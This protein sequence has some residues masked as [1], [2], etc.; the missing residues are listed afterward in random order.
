MP[1]TLDIEPLDASFGAV[2][3]GFRIAELDDASWRELYATWLRYALLVFP[4]QHLARAEQIAFARRFGS[5]EFETA[6]ISNVKS[7]GTLRIEKDND[8]M[9]KVLKGNMGWHAD[10]T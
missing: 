10:S 7:D 9:M 1:H 8:D 3:T 4:G 5:L 2:V 6:A